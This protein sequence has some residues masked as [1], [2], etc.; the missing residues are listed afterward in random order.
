MPDFG[1]VVG[2][3]GLVL[4]YL[5]LH[6]LAGALFF[7]RKWNKPFFRAVMESAG[8]EIDRRLNREGRASQE[9]F[10]RGFVACFIIG[11]SAFIIG[12]ALESIA[13]HGYGW[14][15]LLVFL[16]LNVSAMG[17]IRMMRQALQSLHE[18]NLKKATQIVQP[19]AQDD[20][21]NADAHTIAR[22]ALE[23]SAASLNDFFV[24]PIFWFLLLQTPG[25]AVYSA[26][27][28]LYGVFGQEDSRHRAFGAAVRV[29]EAILNYV[30]A[31]LTAI[32]IAF[33]ALFV[34]KSS[35]LKGLFTAFAQSKK[36]RP[37]NRGILVAAM[38]G[39]LGI[40][41]GGPIKHNN[42]YTASHGWVGPEG[43]SAKASEE[44][45]KRGMVLHFTVFLGVFCVMSFLTMARLYIS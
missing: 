5:L 7:S 18:K 33:G 34:S 3:P 20:L 39:G 45:V 43:S 42:N 31:R 40:T 4:V 10:V 23:S 41:L 36:I 37:V 28:A 8:R 25:L 22:R 6:L 24:A 14:I 15:G 19:F 1:Q 21:A 27:T 9:L 2:Y 32:F 11:V 16:S 17:P 29:S 44:D 35:P 12:L 26:L 13:V 38:A 30:P